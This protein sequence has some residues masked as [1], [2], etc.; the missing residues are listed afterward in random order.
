MLGL[1]LL[2]SFEAWFPEIAARNRLTKLLRARHVFRHGRRSDT[3]TRQIKIAELGTRV[4]CYALSLKR[5]RA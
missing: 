5:L 4:P 1:P 3:N 2:P